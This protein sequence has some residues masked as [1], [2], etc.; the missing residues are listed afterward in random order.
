MDKYLI[1]NADDFGYD[2]ETNETVE[3]L[4]RSERITSASLLACAPA[5]ADAADRAK[6]LDFAVGA[7]LSLTSDGA[8]APW[9]CLS[10]AAS[11]GKTLPPAAGTLTFGAKRRDVRR[12]L[13]A[14]TAFIEALG[15]RID[16]ADAHAGALYGLAG[17]RF[18]LDV[19]DLCA[20]K[21]LPFR[22]P[23]TPDFF[24][25]TLGGRFRTPLRLLHGRIARQAL[26][27]GVPLPDDV[28]SD[29]RAP[30]EIGSRD[31]LF[32][33]YLNAVASCGPG[34]T[35][36]FLHPRKAAAA[37]GSAWQKRLWEY[38]LLASGRLLQAAKE[39]GVTVVSPARAYAL[40]RG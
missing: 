14:Q 5:A 27:K 34:V 38:E 17:R 9:R 30:A 15:C 19:F 20:E 28:F 18:Y 26:A 12:E 29:P 21:Q 32:A 37:P 31:A 3:T 25:R 2:P 10:G 36:I 16:H 4:I 13:A 33:Y 24:I 7:H 1:L 40:E 23:K 22:F 8:D 39:H 35:E 6:K 11:I